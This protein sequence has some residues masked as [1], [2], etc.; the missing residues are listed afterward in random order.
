MVVRN[1]VFRV[2]NKFRS[3]LGKRKSETTNKMSLR[4]IRSKE[5]VLN[6]FTKNNRW[7]SRL[8]RLKSE[9]SLGTKFEN[10]VS[11]ESPLYDANFRRLAMA[12]GRTTNNK[13]KHDVQGFKKKI[14]EFVK[15]HGRA[16]MSYSREKF[17][18]EGNLRAKLDR[19]TLTNKDMTFLGEVYAADPCHKSGI[20]GKYRAIINEALTVSKPLIR[21]V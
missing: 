15:E 8:G 1:K 14:L 9:R 20:P 17:E 18:G 10:Y 21:L 16:P 5:K 4:G 19:Y 7:P 3:I 13:R 12:T 2:I 6:F 11:K